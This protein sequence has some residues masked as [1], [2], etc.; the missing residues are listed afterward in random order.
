MMRSPKRRMAR[1]SRALVQITFSLLLALAAPMSGAELYVDTEPDPNPLRPADTSSPRDT[2]RSFLENAN[3]AVDAW[4]RDEL[5]AKS[6]RAYLRAMETLDLGSTPHSDTW[7]IRTERLL[8]LKELLDRIEL[9][10]ESAIPGDS[11]VADGAVL[12]WTIPDTRITIARI[13]E[14]PRAGEFLFSAGT[15]EKLHRYYAHARH[16]PY[17]PGIQA[18]YYEDWV[19]SER[20]DRARE[21]RI[22]NRLKPVDTSSPRSTL[23]GFLDSINRA[24]AL[25]IE[26][27]AALTATPPTMT[28]QEAR[29]VDIAAAKLLRRAVHTLDLSQVPEVLRDDIG[30]ETALQ[31]KE[32]LDRMR[33]PPVDSVPDARMIAVARE[34]ADGP[35]RWRYPN[36]EIE[37]VEL[38]EGAQQGQFLFS[39]DT[40]AHTGD[41]YGQIREH[42]YRSG[43]SP[44][45]WKSP[46]RSEGFYEYYISTAGYMVPRINVLGRFVEELPA[47]MKTVHGGQT[48]WQ[49]VAMLLCVLAFILF[50]WAIHRLIRRTAQGL[51][52]PLDH[53]LTILTPIVIATVAG[54]LAGFINNDINVT[55]HLRKAVVT[56]GSVIVIAMVA[57]AVFLLCKAI[58]ET[59]VDRPRMREKSSEVALLRIGAR[60]LGFLLGAWIVIGGIRALGADLIPLLAGLGVG[61]LALALAAQSTIANFIGG[62]ILYV[63]KPVRVGEFCR[64]GEDPNPGWLRIGTVEEIGLLSTR[65]RGIDRTVTTIPNAEFSRMHIVNLTKRDQRLLMTTLQLRYETTPDQLRY[66]L[67]RLREL[68]LGHP[69]VT[70]D[71]ARVRFVGFSVYSLDVEIFAY[72]RCVEQDTFLAVQEDLFLRM[73]DIVSEAGS[74]FAFPSQTAYL[75][76]DAG[77]D[78]ERAATAESRVGQQ[79]ATGK[80]PFPEFEEEERERLEDILDYPPK[81]SHDYQPR[82]GTSDT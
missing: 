62:L 53:W 48:L 8:L 36:T 23:A 11:E 21:Q 4:R 19:R 58:A 73:A 17:K 79:R 50:A 25:V 6:T 29:E 71:P 14:G 1:S 75:A 34:Q 16:L 52:S 38:T 37:I 51:H 78:D 65:L 26:A 44:T 56:G 5:D 80:L 64:Y 40:V 41:F 18:G 66:I 33:L 31:L 47:W 15:V 42:A 22:R 46:A 35:I 77:L 49:W 28:M 12:Q 70:P 32:I 63:N 67:T 13:G 68:L 2:L 9:P 20:T 27:D 69:M 7:W 60:V 54:L 43:T 72:L 45:E 76:R 61:G 3:E 10:P 55:G 59:V 24:Y 39:A 82:P 74:G 81:G 57:W 30:S